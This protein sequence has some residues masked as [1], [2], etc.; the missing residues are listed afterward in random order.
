[1]DCRDTRHHLARSGRRFLWPPPEAA[2]AAR[3]FGGAIADHRYG[4]VEGL[5]ELV[6][7][8]EEKLARENGIAVSPA[9]RVVVTAGGNIAFMN[10]LLAI[11]D[12]GDEIIL[13]MPYYFNHEMAI[14]MAGAQPV[15]V[16]TTPEFQLD[17]DAIA[18]RDHAADARDRDR[19]AE[20]SDR[21]RLSG[22]GAP[23]GE[24]A[25]PTR[26]I[27]HIHDEAYEYFT[28][29]GAAHFSP[30]SIDG[31]RRTRSR[32]IRCRR[33]MVSRAG[34]SATWSCPTHSVGRQQD[35]GH[36][37]DLPAGRVAAGRDAA[38]AIGAGY[39][40]AHLDGLVAP[41]GSCSR[42]SRDPSVPWTSGVGR[43]VL[44]FPECSTLDSMAMVERL[45][46]EHRVAAIPG[47]AF[48]ETRGCTLRDLVWR[49]RCWHGA[50]RH[51]PAHPWTAG[52]GLTG[53]K[54]LTWNVNGIR[55]RHAQLDAL[56]AEECPDIVCLQEIKAAPDQ[57]PELLVAATDHWT[58]WHG[59]GA[60]PAWR[61]SSVTVFS[62]NGPS[63]VIRPS[64]WNIVSSSPTL[65]LSK[66]PRFTSQME[67]RTTRRS[68]GSSMGSPAGR[69][70]RLGPAGRY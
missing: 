60:T 23:R 69:L 14:T 15:L 1:M 19:L 8:L 64:M 62:R 2:A 48:G 31:Q 67:A 49:T 55:A 59:A 41:V 51:H 26:G 36:D 43:R 44:L 22:A 66:W 46:R 25:L 20:Q 53:V 13:P 17:L 24:R 54:I 29:G 21:R 16:P 6:S 27:F 70:K 32:S 57:V 28:Y 39:A 33:R 18:P 50:R 58:F 9:S 37:P 42:P 65:A 34:A 11:A 7:A 3:S 45:I 52:P 5:P 61:C 35:P 10:A 68:C 30:G 63:S 47:S 40:R 12:P 38:A 56:L 4:P